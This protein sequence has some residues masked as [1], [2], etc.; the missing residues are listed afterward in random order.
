MEKS[1][2]FKKRS[3]KSILIGFLIAFVLFFCFLEISQIS[4]IKGNYYYSSNIS[5]LLKTIFEPVH[6]CLL[7]TIVEVIASIVLLF[8][9]EKLI[10]NKDNK[11]KKIIDYIIIPIIANVINFIVILIILR[12]NFSIVF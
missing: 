11:T 12:M 10:H 8:L 3:I 1:D 2:S 5:I 7:C 9:I 6:Y 4:L